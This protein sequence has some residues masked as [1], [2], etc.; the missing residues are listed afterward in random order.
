MN[1]K[2]LQTMIHLC[3]LFLFVFAILKLA[4]GDWFAITI[5][6]S[7]I[8]DFGYFIDGN[9]N[10]KNLFSFITT[11]ITYF[12]YLCA[13]CCKWKLNFKEL[14][15]SLLFIIPAFIFNVF[16]INYSVITNC[17]IMIIL[18]FLLKSKYKNFIFVFTAHFLG[19]ILISFI[20]SEQLMFI[21]TNTISA[22]IIGIDQFVWLILYYLYSNKFKEFDMGLWYPPLWGNC[23]KKFLENQEK[24]FSNIIEKCERKGN[25]RKADKF[26]VS[27]ERIK[28]LISENEK[29][30]D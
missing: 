2:V 26:R 1:K 14:F 12:F 18:P 25:K 15:I 23:K 28:I 17:I 22:L 27:R 7:K 21:K 20:R 5:N 8:V 10:I 19:Q 30:K 4:F 24:H 29:E 13:C 16:F 6:N 9:I 3:W 11:I